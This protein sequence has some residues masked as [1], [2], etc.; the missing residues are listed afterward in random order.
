MRPNPQETAGLITFTEEF[1][2]GKIRIRYFFWSLFS[3][4]TEI[5]REYQD[6][7]QYIPVI[8]PYAEIHL[9]DKITYSLVF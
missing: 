9:P 3:L 7:S 4:F 6:K 1:I 8:R 2:N 5:I